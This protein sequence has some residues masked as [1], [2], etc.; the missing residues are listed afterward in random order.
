ML[1]VKTL[2]QLVDF[3]K[4]YADIIPEKTEVSRIIEESGG[5]ESDF[6]EVMGQEH[7]KR[8]LEVAAAGSHNLIMVGVPGR[9]FWPSGYPPFSRRSLLMNPLKPPKFSAYPACSRM[10]RR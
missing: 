3:F 6:A 9:P 1:P 7:V 5:F 2:S 4:G 10:I 8:A